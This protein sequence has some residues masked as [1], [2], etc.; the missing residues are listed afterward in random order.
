MVGDGVEA[1]TEGNEFTGLGHTQEHFA[2]GF[3][4]VAGGGED[5]FDVT[6][7]GTFAQKL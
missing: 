7:I 6:R 2:T 4:V 3:V 5:G 1:M